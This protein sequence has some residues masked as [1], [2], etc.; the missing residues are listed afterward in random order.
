MR[1]ILAGGGNV[2]RSLLAILESQAAILRR[3]YGLTVVVVGMADSRGA[4]LDPAGLDLAGLRSAKSAGRSVGTIPEVGRMAMTPLELVREVEADL[5]FE[6]TPVDLTTGQPGLDLV[7]EALQRGLHCVLANKGP[8]ALAYPELAAASDLA[9]GGAPALRFSACVGGALP[10]I[11]LG[12][13][14]LA[15]ARI[16]K[17]EAILNGTCQG[18]LRAMEDGQEFTAAVAEMQ[19]RGVAETDPSLD[20]DGWDQAVKLVILANAVLGRPTVLGDV[21]VRGIRDVTAADLEAA[22]RRGERVVLLG[23]AERARP[24]HD[25]ALTVAPT[26]L[27]KRHRLA[28]MSADEMGV[29]YYT[30]VSGILHATSEESSAV[31][32]AAAMLRDLIE[33]AGGRPESAPISR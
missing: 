17:V 9:A 3:Q 11:N 29:I 8:L 15:G 7:R 31:P 2:G 22:D 10:T 23:V 1:V 18:I 20:I 28:R 19:R 32:T 27:P 21:S 6:A 13:R 26:A 30:D 5:V 14:D 25:W 12:R 16:L 24:D 33:I 4:A